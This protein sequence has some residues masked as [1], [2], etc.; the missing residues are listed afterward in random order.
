MPYV[1]T[2]S[3]TDQVRV[4]LA[5][6]NE[7]LQIIWYDRGRELEELQQVV[8]SL[9][10]LHKESLCFISSVDAGGDALLGFTRSLRREYKLWTICCIILPSKRPSYSLEDVAREVLAYPSSEQEIFVDTDGTVCAERIVKSCP[11]RSIVSFDPNTPWVYQRGS[12]SHTS[13]PLVPSA[14]VLIHVTGMSKTTSGFRTFVGRVEGSQT[15]CVGITSH[16]LGSYV[17]AHSGSIMELPG[18][19]ALSSIGAH[20]LAGVVA[21]LGIGST[22]FCH[23]E[24]LKDSRVLVTYSDTSMGEAIC[25]I[26]ED[27]GIKV[28]RLTS[29][30]DVWEARAALSHQ[31]R[32]LVSAREGDT[33]VDVDALVHELQSR[34]AFL[35]DDPNSG[36]M[37]ILDEDPW[38]IG[39]AIAMSFSSSLYSETTGIL[40]PTDF[41]PDLPAEV[42]SCYAL[43][44]STKVYVLIGGIGGLGIHIARWMYE[45]CRSHA[46]PFFSFPSDSV[47]SM[48]PVT[49][50]SHPALELPTSSQKT[51]SSLC[52]CWLTFEHW[53]ISN[54]APR[55]WT[56]HQL[57]T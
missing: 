11:P 32:F 55:P 56:H 54:C 39:D 27:R 24:R 31:P 20:V 38:A 26:Y 8:R 16:P 6:K 48:E 46:H 34:T 23:P 42:P 33:S 37:R 4:Q 40:P 41:L 21:V 47:I 35:W 13:G 14:C 57:R 50:F 28:V 18:D 3:L 44:D 36:I 52:G 17:V 25:G 53:T 7:G 51:N 10:P 15:L 2:S 22:R 49:L 19:A 5:T 45:V 30:A 1:H 12:L 43:F 29:Q 9:D